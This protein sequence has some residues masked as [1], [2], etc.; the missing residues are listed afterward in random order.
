[1][2]GQRS[3]PRPTF[4]YEREVNQYNDARSSLF[5]VYSYF[6]AR[7]LLLD[8]DGRFNYKFGKKKFFFL[9]STGPFSETGLYPITE[10]EEFWENKFLKK[11]SG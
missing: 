7:G 3:A 2:Q 1:M 10:I 8:E 11:M 5:T 4:E 9:V 6:V